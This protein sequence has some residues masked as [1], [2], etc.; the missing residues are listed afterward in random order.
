MSRVL[1]LAVGGLAASAVAAGAPGTRDGQV[2]AATCSDQSAARFPNAFGRPDN[3]VV[4][5]LAFS[6][7]RRS[8]LAFTAES[9]RR[10]GGVKAP[11]ILRA[12][13]T[14][15][16]SI[17]RPARSWVR[18][19]HGQHGRGGNAFRA[20][21]HSIRFESCGRRRAQSVVDGRPATFWSGFF[22]MRRVP[23]CLPLTITVDGHAPV[24]RSLP[25]AGGTCETP[26]VLVP[27]LVGL[28]ARRASARLRR[29]GLRPA[30]HRGGIRY[31]PAGDGLGRSL[32]L[33]PG[34]ASG[35]R[36]VTLQDGFPTRT[37]LAWGSPVAF[38]TQPAPGRYRFIRALGGGEPERLDS[39]AVGRDGRRLTLGVTGGE[40][41]PLDH[42]DVAP[43]KRW[44]LLVPFVIGGRAC[45]R[46]DY[47]RHAELRL[48][49]RLAGR[50]VLERPPDVPDS[51]LVNQHAT[52]FDAARPSPDGRTV[53]VFYTYGGCDSL[54]GIRV[55]ERPGA[56]EI[57]LLQGDSGSGLACAEIAR[58]GLALVRLPSPLGG[59]RI[60]DGTS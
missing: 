37:R 20:R 29:A 21:P 41:D 18:L 45:S 25:V 13:H 2:A 60:V 24:H 9:L 48:P 4:G 8:A 57:T 5:P 22:V 17:D 15:L 27:K 40:C 10:F 58:A 39:V 51:S 56:V 36:R 50:P 6:G 54:A 49:E 55:A 47:E 14:V 11:A 28:T 59:G 7:L 31:E 26:R 38:G 42:V 44:V 12:G 23:A 34:H 19:I 46:R 33:E 16:V 43:R 3:L 35:P 1:L 30:A 52:A 53:V 32:E